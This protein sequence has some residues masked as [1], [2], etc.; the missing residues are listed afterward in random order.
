MRL[1]MNE[2]ENEPRS[3][4]RASQ[5]HKSMHII[6]WF[7]ADFY[8]CWRCS[9]F[10]SLQFIVLCSISQVAVHCELIKLYFHFVL[11]FFSEQVEFGG[12]E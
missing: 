5:M 1:Y 7:D 9:A 11:E 12:F 10:D 8:I 3:Y 2:N 6:L 4:V